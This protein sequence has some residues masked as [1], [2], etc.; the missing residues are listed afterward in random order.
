MDFT[1]HVLLFQRFC[2]SFSMSFSHA[3]YSP[4]K[5]LLPVEIAHQSIMIRSAWKTNLLLHKVRAYVAMSWSNQCSSRHCFSYLQSTDTVNNN[6]EK[7]LKSA[8]RE[9]LNLCFTEFVFS[10]FHFFT[11]LNT[12]FDRRIIEKSFS[13]L[14]ISLLYLKAVYTCC[15]K[16]VA[17]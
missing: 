6:N 5:W 17:L 7:T 10:A 8:S 16:R 13:R 4:S 15:E 1:L 12:I 14:L 2:L 11:S 3:V 9:D